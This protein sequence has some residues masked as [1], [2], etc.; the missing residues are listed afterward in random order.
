[1]CC[2]KQTRC[3]IKR[4]SVSLQDFIRYFIVME[5]QSKATKT[6]HIKFN[7]LPRFRLK[8]VFGKCLNGKV[9]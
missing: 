8:E 5:L 9:V 3:L 4:L 7:E 6:R 1:M 2:I